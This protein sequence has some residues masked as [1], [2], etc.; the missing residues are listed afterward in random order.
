MGGSA[1][2]TA[3]LKEAYMQRLDYEAVA[4]EGVR[5]LG[6]VH[7]Y[8]AKSGLPLALIDMTYLRVSQINGCPYCIDMHT[9]DAMKHGVAVE[10]LMLVSAWRDTGALFSPQERAALQWAEALTLIA[11]TGA[12]DADYQ[13]AAAQFGEKDLVDLTI[14]IGLMNAYNRIAIGFRR[15]PDITSPR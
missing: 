2:P 8:V 5:A 4:A 10:K 7:H 12:P 14:A 11:Q 9:R 15:G 6:G 3:A 1:R 13:A